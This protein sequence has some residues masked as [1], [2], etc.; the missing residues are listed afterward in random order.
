MDILGGEHVYVDDLN[1]IKFMLSTLSRFV[2]SQN[3]Y[4]YH[5]NNPLIM[6]KISFENLIPKTS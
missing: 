3:Y 1:N 2:N 4:Y 6:E 5:T